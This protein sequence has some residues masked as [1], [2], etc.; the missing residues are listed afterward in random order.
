M[1]VPPVGF[2]W[3]LLW[4]FLSCPALWSH[5]SPDTLRTVVRVLESLRYSV[6]TEH[7][8]FCCSNPFRSFFKYCCDYIKVTEP[9]V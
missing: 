1:A 4:V 3:A 2:L 6:S 7:V 5:V 9:S 8:C